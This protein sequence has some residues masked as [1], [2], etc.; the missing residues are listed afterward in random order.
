MKASHFYF[1]YDRC[2]ISYCGRQWSQWTVLSESSD[3]SIDAIDQNGKSSDAFLELSKERYF[4]T[5]LERTNSMSYELSTSIT[6][7][8]V[9][10]VDDGS[11]IVQSR[12]CDDGYCRHTHIVNDTQ[13][14]FETTRINVVRQIDTEH[15]IIIYWCKTLDSELGYESHMNRLVI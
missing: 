12:R 2:A 5:S 14:R 13:S 10:K 9:N 3:H 11:D 6:C 8:M 7:H 15:H 4:S 1:P